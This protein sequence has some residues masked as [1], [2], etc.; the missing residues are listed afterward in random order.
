[1][2][3]NGPPWTRTRNAF[4]PRI[5]SPLRYQFR[6]PTHNDSCGALRVQWT[7]VQRRPKRS[8]DF[9]P[10]IF[11]LRTR[12]PE[13]LDE[14]ANIEITCNEPCRQVHER[15]SLTVAAFA[16]CVQSVFQGSVSMLPMPSAS[17]STHGSLLHAKTA[18]VGKIRN[19]RLSDNISYTVCIIANQGVRSAL[20]FLPNFSMR[21]SPFSRS[22]RDSNSSYE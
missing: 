4:K 6:S 22:D 12:N 16:V 8:G 15:C 9:E 18:C 17:L 10:D 21:T 20:L 5:Y 2:H 11:W 7:L 13:P 14:G 3:I 19:R 1:M